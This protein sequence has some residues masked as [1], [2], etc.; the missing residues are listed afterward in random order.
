MK[1]L[2]RLFGLT[3]ITVSLT[4]ALLN[5]SAESTR[6]LEL[7]E[8][9]STAMTTTQIVMRKQ[10]EDSYYGT[11]AAETYFMSSDDYLEYFTD[12]LG[13]LITSNSTYTVDC[14]EADYI[15]GILSVQVN[16]TYTDLLGYDKTLSIK[17]TSIVDIVNKT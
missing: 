7:N 14:I 15:N 12:H 10:I 6:F 1:L 11:R 3:I 4:V 9:T 16:C 2:I 8:A 5:Y 13:I 17:R